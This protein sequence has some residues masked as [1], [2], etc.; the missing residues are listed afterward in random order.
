[1]DS[2]QPWFGRGEAVS[3]AETREQPGWV[4]VPPYVGADQ[5][6]SVLRVPIIIDGQH[7]GSFGV[8][9]RQPRTYT[10]HHRHLATLLGDRVTLAL[11]NARLYEE[12]Q[13]RARAAEELARLRNDFVASVSHELRTPLTT[14][15]GYA[16]LLRSRW[17]QL[18]DTQRLAQMDRIVLAANR[19]FHLVEDLL[20]LTRL[21]SGVPLVRA[22]PVAL[23]NAVQRAS[24]DI[25][26]VYRSQTIEVEGAPALL[27]LAEP[28]RVHQILVNLLDNAAKYA[29]EG[30]PIHVSWH[31]HNDTVVLR[32]RDHGEG[33]PGQTLPYLFT[34]FGRGP[35]SRVR[36]GHV[37][38][39][40]GLYLGRL[41]AKAM[42]G[43]LDLEQTGP[44]GST[45]ILTLPLARG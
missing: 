28:E 16:E 35:H 10:D 2:A 32:V 27:A 44:E 13:K 33:V 19:Q 30:T 17:G 15:L 6:R 38:T 11:R 45:F 29:P 31:V 12:E 22:I 34:R 1:M 41:L 21:E 43:D 8:S 36:A 40:L 14:I 39:G 20:S 9:S 18:T 26:S 4:D 25:C 37:G 24:E 42:Q 3:I 5:I 7:L 23:S